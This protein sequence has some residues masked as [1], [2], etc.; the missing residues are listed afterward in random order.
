MK[1]V[2][3]DQNNELYFKKSV[4]CFEIYLFPWYGGRNSTSAG[5]SRFQRLF[6][7]LQPFDA[8]KGIQSPK[9]RS[10]THGWTTDRW[11]LV[12]EL[13][14]VTSDWLFTLGQMS[15]P[16]LLWTKADVLK[17]NGDDDGID[18]VWKDL[19][20]FIFVLCSR[21]CVQFWKLDWWNNLYI[22]NLYQQQ[23]TSIII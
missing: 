11:W 9:T 2:V 13:T 21:W 14:L 22:F 1:V 4:I 12:A 20:K 23:N 5:V 8:R 19:V 10:N 17:I 3:S 7:N 15:N 16:S 6:P 18:L